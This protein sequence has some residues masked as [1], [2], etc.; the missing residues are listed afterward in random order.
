[1]GG[2]TSLSSC[3][4]VVGGRVASW[5]EG[6]P[7]GGAVAGHGPRDAALRGMGHRLEEVLGEVP[8]QDQFAAALLRALNCG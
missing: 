5:E 3:C 4:C 2:C 7:H 1:M 8:A 6:Q